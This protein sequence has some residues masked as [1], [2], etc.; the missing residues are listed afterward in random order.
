MDTS[1]GIIPYLTDTL[2]NLDHGINQHSIMCKQLFE[3]GRGQV[4]TLHSPDLLSYFYKDFSYLCLHFFVH[5]LWCMCNLK[6][7]ITY[8][9]ILR[10]I[11]SKGNVQVLPNLHDYVTIVLVSHA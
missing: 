6:V 3:A 1:S 5:T 11:L 8:V 10:F 2:F 4:D 7:Y 9:L